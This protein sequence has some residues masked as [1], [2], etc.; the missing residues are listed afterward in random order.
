[1]NAQSLRSALDLL[2]WRTSGSFESRNVLIRCPFA[3]WLHKRGTDNEP[4]MAVAPVERGSSPAICNSCGTKGTL[5]QI[6]KMAREKGLVAENVFLKVASMEIGQTAG[7]PKASSPKEVPKV[8]EWKEAL[9][10]IQWKTVPSYILSRGFTKQTCNEWGLGFD[11][12]LQRTVFTVRDGRG[13]LV[14]LLSRRSQ[15]KCKVRYPTYRGWDPSLTL[16]GEHLA[17]ARRGH[18]LILVEGPLDALYV[19]QTTLYPVVA[20]MGLHLSKERI[21]TLRQ[22]TNHLSQP[23]ILCLDNDEAGRAATDRISRRLKG[24]ITRGVWRPDH[25]EYAPGAKRKDPPECP[26]DLL[27]EIL[28]TKTWI[29]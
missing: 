14:G 26:P 19:W 27:K 23:L 16:Y 6:V 13:A 10:R 21:L 20:L 28:E 4:S 2:G 11:P 8:P 5:L 3:K 24:K 17:S 25:P 15:Q 18:P 1:M 12:L 29:A 7:T 9:S 22:L